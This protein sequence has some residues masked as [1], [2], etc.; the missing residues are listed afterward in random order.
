MEDKR[1]FAERRLALISVIRER[2]YREGS[3]Q[4]ASGKESS[5]YFDLKETTLNQ[6]GMTLIGSLAVDL[7]EE[8]GLNPLAVGGMTLGADPVSVAIAFAAA[9]RGKELES[10]IVR[11]EPKGHGTEQWI[12]GA[13]SYPKGAKVL[14]IEDVVTTGGSGIKS[15]KIVQNAGFEVLGL[16][17]VVDRLEGGQDACKEAGIPLFSLCALDDFRSKN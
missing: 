8:K 13:K 2:S 1:S 9:D 4:L 5:Y 14:M 3:F 12:E 10:F 11:K 17:T 6:E 16:F 7:M 15:V